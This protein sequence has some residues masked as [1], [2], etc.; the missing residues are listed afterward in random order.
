MRARSPFARLPRAPHLLGGCADCGVGTY[1]L[2]EYYMVA[3]SVWE[4]AWAGRRKAWHS[5]PGQEY[6][7]IGCLEARIGRTLNSGDFTDAPVNNPFQ[8]DI[9]VRLRNRLTTY[10]G[11][12][13]DW[14]LERM[15]R[16]LPEHEQEAARKHWRERQP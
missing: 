8:D 9:S 15:I 7:C 1:T 5:L 6:L 12:L 13:F 10:S 16:N 14:L 3:D 2:G 11:S 4:Q